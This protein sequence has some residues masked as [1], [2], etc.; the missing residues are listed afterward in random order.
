MQ[1]VHTAASSWQMLQPGLRGVWPRLL[2]L[3]LLASFISGEIVM[4]RLWEGSRHR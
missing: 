4:D 1:S 3:L 2:C